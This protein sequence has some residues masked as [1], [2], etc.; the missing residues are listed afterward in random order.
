MEHQLGHLV[1]NKQTFMGQLPI[2]RLRI[3]LSNAFLGFGAETTVKARDWCLSYRRIGHGI[4]P[5]LWPSC[6]ELLLPI[7]GY[8]L[9]LLNDSMQ[10]LL[11][12]G[13]SETCNS[14]VGV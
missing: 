14:S 4:N 11:G 2:D 5:T 6:L 13:S 8:F 10:I 9:L 7:N 1:P 3:S 12:Y